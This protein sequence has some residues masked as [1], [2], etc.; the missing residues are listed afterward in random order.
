MVVIAGGVARMRR[1]VRAGRRGAG[2]R[3]CC[4]GTVFTKKTCMNTGA[5]S[6][7][8]TGTPLRARDFK[9]GEKR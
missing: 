4:V 5:R 1:Q 9:S 8:R 6:R 7:D 2:L 3:S